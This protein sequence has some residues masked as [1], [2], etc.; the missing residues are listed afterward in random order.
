MDVSQSYVTFLFVRVSVFLEQF[1]GG[2]RKTDRNK[3]RN[4]ISG[5]E[6]SYELLPI[7]G[8]FG[9]FVVT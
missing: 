6:N 7:R 8:E 9:V 5:K 3:D 2:R 1:F 4:I